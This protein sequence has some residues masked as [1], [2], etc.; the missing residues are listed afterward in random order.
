[1]QFC[2]EQVKSATE[3]YEL[4]KVGFGGQMTASGAT[5][6]ENAERSGHP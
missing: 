5:A 1:M 3:A 6:V 2:F 4:S